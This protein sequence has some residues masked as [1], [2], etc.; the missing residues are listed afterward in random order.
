MAI[1]EDAAVVIAE[2]LAVV[3]IVSVAVVV[4]D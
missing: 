1:I 2:L 3:S 4:F